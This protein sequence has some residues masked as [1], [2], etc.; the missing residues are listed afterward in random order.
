MDEKQKMRLEKINDLIL[1]RY[2]TTGVQDAIKKAV[3][4]KNLTPIYPVKSL[5][6]FT[7]DGSKAVFQDCML[8]YPHTTVREFTGMLSSEME[9]HF[10]YAEGLS[11]QRMGEDEE[12]TAENNIIK[13]TTAA[14]ETSNVTFKPAKTSDPKSKESKKS[15]AEEK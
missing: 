15:K 1:L 10:L 8:I 14:S 12:L 6:N 13:I 2:G 4:I 3:E 9:K 7:C 5:H 11:G